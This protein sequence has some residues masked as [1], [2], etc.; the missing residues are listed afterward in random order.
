MPDLR[1]DRDDLVVVAMNY[2]GRKIELLQIFAEVG[3]GERLIAVV[4]FLWPA[5]IPCIQNQSADPCDTLALGRLK[6]KKG[7]LAKSL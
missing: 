5:N 6:P 7:P 2:Q 1:A 3:L 4:R